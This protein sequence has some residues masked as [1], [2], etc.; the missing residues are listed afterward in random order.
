MP[1]HNPTVLI[2]R[3]IAR[4]GHKVYKNALDHYKVQY[5]SFCYGLYHSDEVKSIYY[6]AYTKIYMYENGIVKNVNL[7]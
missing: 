3:N 4:Y 2:R 7:T 6:Y 1:M 5:Y